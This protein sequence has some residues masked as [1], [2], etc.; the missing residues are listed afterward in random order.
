MSKIYICLP[1]NGNKSLA[2]IQLLAQQ[3]ECDVEI[4]GG[5]AAAEIIDGRLSNCDGIVVILG[6]ALHELNAIEPTILLAKKHGKKI[7][8]V[9][10]PK[11]TS[12]V[13][14][15]AL[16]KSSLGKIRSRTSS[17]GCKEVVRRDL[18]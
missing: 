4:A 15:Q 11:S 8:G 12:Q 9:W 3:C 17:L 18:R 14:P 13:I 16:E 7:I 5:E 1:L 10:P 2:S 6:Q